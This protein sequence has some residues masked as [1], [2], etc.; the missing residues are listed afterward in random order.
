MRHLA[1]SLGLGITILAPC[2][3]ADGYHTPFR[4]KKELTSWWHTV[5]GDAPVGPTSGQRVESRREEGCYRPHL[6]KPY[7]QG[8]SRLF[9]TLKYLHGQNV[10]KR[11]FPDL[12][13]QQMISI[14]GAVISLLIEQ[15][16]LVVPS[17][18]GEWSLEV[19]FPGA[20]G[21]G[22][23]IDSYVKRHL[24]EYVADCRLQIQELEK[25]LE[26]ARTASEA[27]AIKGKIQHIRDGLRSESMEGIRKQLS[28]TLRNGGLLESREYR[29]M[30]ETVLTG[31]GEPALHCLFEGAEDVEVEVREGCNEL[32]D[33]ILERALR[34][35][36]GKTLIQSRIPLLFS[37]AVS[38][39]E[40]NRKA[41]FDRL[42]WLTGKKRLGED[43]E[44]WRKYLSEEY[45]PE[46]KDRL[47]EIG[48]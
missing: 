3:V 48:R 46:L 42:E 24:R 19:R 12:T 6:P 45:A 41:A 40:D 9:E 5:T 2:L 20:A 34:K 7:R 30:L 1:L 43:L 29:R 14:Q 32:I 25:A 10:I 39:Y 28:L 37:M 36:S 27:E 13:G 11:E 15:G 22:A 38:R 18:L 35:A 23:K 33:D 21:E 44:A 8:L 17:V 4:S 26:E 31:I 16:A 47:A